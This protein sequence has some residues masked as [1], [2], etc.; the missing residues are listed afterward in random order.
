[1]CTYSGPGQL[2]SQS[3]TGDLGPVAGVGGSGLVVLG[4]FAQSCNKVS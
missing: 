2:Q 1:M 4:K 3:S